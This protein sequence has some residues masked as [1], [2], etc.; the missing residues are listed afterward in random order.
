MHVILQE[1]LVRNAS[2]QI[3]G[4]EGG[5]GKVN[6]TNHAHDV[7]FIICRQGAGLAVITKRL[8]GRVNIL[9][10]LGGWGSVYM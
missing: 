8:P 5:E 7:K 10:A 2:R 1:L 9:D 6:S 3:Q 4:N